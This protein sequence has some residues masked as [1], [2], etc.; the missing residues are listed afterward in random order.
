MVDLILVYIKK[1]FAVLTMIIFW[2]AYC[3]IL[4]NTGDVSQL[5]T[6]LLEYPIETT[7]SNA[8]ELE[9]RNT[10]LK[11]ITALFSF[12]KIIWMLSWALKPFF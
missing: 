3:T 2:T 8:E 11:T 12:I 9:L 6:T 5:S 1:A 10:N 4:L 7:L